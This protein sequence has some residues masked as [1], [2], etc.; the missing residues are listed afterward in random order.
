MTSVAAAPSQTRERGF[1]RSA[2]GGGITVLLLAILAVAVAVGVV[3]RVMGGQS[4]T[5]LTGS[6]QPTYSPGD[7]VVAVPQDNYAIGDVVTF[8]PKP[9]D[10]TLV[11]HRIVGVQMG[12]SGTEYVT[13]GD[14]N[15]A[16]DEPIQDK[17]IVGEVMYHVPYV[18][19]VSQ[20]AG[21]HRTAL[22][23][24]AGAV[25]IG[26]GIYTFGSGLIGKRRE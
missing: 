11:T 6:M 15:G 1:W 9:N 21:T 24:I 16:K 19:H 26:Y 2:L 25:L 18:G 3:P 23:A 14:A 17:Q 12:E 4:L 20:L 13:Q 5:V 7:V 8:M 10:P 22:V